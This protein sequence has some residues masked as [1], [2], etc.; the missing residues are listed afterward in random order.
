MNNEFFI[1][2][3]KRLPEIAKRYKNELPELIY[4]FNG[5]A[6]LDFT[7]ED[8][9]FKRSLKVLPDPYVSEYYGSGI[10]ALCPGHDIG[11]EEI[12]TKFKI[13][14][15]G[16]VDSN[17]FFSKEL[18]IFFNGVKSHPEGNNKIIKK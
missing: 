18:G 13:N 14:I 5:N 6:L 3:T 12:C 2:L 8:P 17:G 10:N 7:L 1:C 4:H 15:K 9:I 16:Y 11:A